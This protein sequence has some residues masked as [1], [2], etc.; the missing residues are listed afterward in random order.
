MG[1]VRQVFRRVWWHRG[2][3]H[4]V[5]RTADRAGT[6]THPLPSA[7]PSSSSSTS[8]AGLVRGGHERVDTLRA[9]MEPVNEHW[10]RAVLNLL[11]PLCPI[12]GSGHSQPGSPGG[13]RSKRMCPSKCMVPCRCPSQ[14]SHRLS[15]L[16]RF[17]CWHSAWWHTC[18]VQLRAGTGQQ[19]DPPTP[20]GLHR[21]WEHSHST[22]VLPGT[23]GCSAEPPPHRHCAAQS[24]SEL[25]DCS[26]RAA[27]SWA[28]R[29]GERALGAPGAP[30]PHPPV[31]DVPCWD[32]GAP[33]PSVL[34]GGLQGHSGALLCL[35]DQCPHG[36]TEEA[37]V[38]S[39]TMLASRCISSDCAPGL[40]LSRAFTGIYF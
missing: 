36:R 15:G 26:R 19:Q 35:R 25:W 21:G 28:W 3:T 12:N 31:A 13:G 18:G 16:L 34:P 30:D 33:K 4:S 40:S 37:S 14:A 23:G 8:E 5:P 10:G 20:C 38:C 11:A 39:K 22:A 17:S 2:G 27:H 1:R 9:R 29:E 24:P 32:E 6:C 7:G